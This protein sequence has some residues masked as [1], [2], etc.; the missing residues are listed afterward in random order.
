MNDTDLNIQIKFTI[1]ED[2]GSSFSDALYIPMSVYETLSEADI[3]AMKQS[4]YLAWRDSL[5]ASQNAPAPD[6]IESIVNID[7]QIDGL[8]QQRATVVNDVVVQQS[9]DIEVIEQ[10]VEVKKAEIE[11]SANVEPITQETVQE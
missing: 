5:L 9:I 2:D 11:Q 10:L 7:Q 8:M 3:D 6:P 4:R 1:T